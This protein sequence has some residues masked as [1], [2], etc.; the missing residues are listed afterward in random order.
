MSAAAAA[1]NV[2]LFMDRNSPKVEAS[3]LQLDLMK[4]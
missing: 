3:P 2:K 1:A 4:N